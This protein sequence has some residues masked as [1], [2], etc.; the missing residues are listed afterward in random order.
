VSEPPFLPP[1]EPST[2]G[3]GRQEETGRH[4]LVQA[5]VPVMDVDGFNVTTLGIVVFSVASVLAGIYYPRLDRAGNGWWLG[6][7]VSGLVLG[8]VGM[9]YCLWR[10]SRRRA[11]RWDRD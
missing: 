6:V 9:A 7:C 5:P 4:F 3:S 11:G 1:D 10:R 2:L 8:F